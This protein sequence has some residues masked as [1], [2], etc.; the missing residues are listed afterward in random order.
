MFVVDVCVFVL[1]CLL[2]FA[3]FVVFAV[4]VVLLLRFLIVLNEC[5]IA[6]LCWFSCS[7]VS[8][9]VS[10]VCCCLFLVLVW[11]WRGFYMFLYVG[12]CVVVVVIV[13]PLMVVAIVY[14]DVVVWF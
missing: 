14:G 1:L 13:F 10:P 5:V 2:R 3:F 11:C 7:L 12:R 4:I 6:V 9:V 8:L